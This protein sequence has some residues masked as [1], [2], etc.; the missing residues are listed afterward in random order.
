MHFLKKV[1]KKLPFAKNQCIFGKKVLKKLYIFSPFFDNFEKPV[2]QE[3]KLVWP[4]P[5]G[6]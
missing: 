2:N 4:K 3:K 1:L 5:N 6:T